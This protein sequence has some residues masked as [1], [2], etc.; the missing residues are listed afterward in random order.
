MDD[1]R[2]EVKSVLGRNRQHYFS[3]EQLHPPE[4]VRALVAS[5]FIERSQAGVSITDLT[6]E[7]TKSSLE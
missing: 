2:I 5:V 1:Q 3:L 7:I 6:E 4:G